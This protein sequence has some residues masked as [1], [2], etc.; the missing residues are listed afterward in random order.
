MSAAPA[1]VTV[2]V[3]SHVYEQ[4][5]IW[6]RYVDEE[7]RGMARAAFYHE[8]D[9]E[10]NRLTIVNGAPGKELN[11]SRLVR[12]AIWKPG[13]TVDDIGA[14]DP[15]VFVPLTPGAYDPQA[16]L[17]DMDAM[18]V[19]HAVVFPT[20]LNEYLPIVENPQAA[21]ALAQGYNDWVWDFAAQTN[22]RVHPVAILPLHS[23]LL[24]RRELDR[25]AE[26]GFTAVEIRPAYFATNV[27]E[28]HSLQEQISRAMQQGL[29]HMMG[30]AEWPNRH[31][32]ETSPFRTVWNHIS[33]LDLVACVHPS[34]GI[35]GPDSIS[36]GAFAER[37]SERLGVPHTIAE[38]IAHMQDADLF[39]T[40]A[41]FHGLLED[42]PSLRLAILHAGTSWVP[43]AL[44]KSETYLWLSPQYAA[45]F[46]C[47]EPEEVWDRHPLV[48]GFDSWEQSVAIMPDRLGDK[49][50]WGSR[51]PNHDAAGPDEAR[52]MLDAEGVD[53]AMIDR[54]MG[55]N[56][57]ALFRLQVPARA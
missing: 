23:S 18:G 40:T 16:R 53:P 42:F 6:D 30:G 4:P 13:M 41:F 54:L 44:E 33:E 12:Q 52:T 45:N 48:V 49:A 43:L 26:K 11:R 22:G 2:D 57:A 55:G 46:V 28:G 19:D 38:P 10:G 1:G 39:V 25:V 7:F 15:D 47:L 32:V 29:R 9:D 35:T 17:A 50:A 37:V 8:V 24:A 31:F 51:Y 27:I 5:E 34:L 36:S 14:L 3:D 20:L 21:A 56:A